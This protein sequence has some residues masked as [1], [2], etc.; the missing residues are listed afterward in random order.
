MHIEP[1]ISYG[2]KPKTPAIKQAFEE[3]FV[4]LL[5]RFYNIF[6]LIISD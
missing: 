6:R 4:N 5:S 2:L 1:W 3:D